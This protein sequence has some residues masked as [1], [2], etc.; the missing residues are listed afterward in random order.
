MMYDNVLCIVF[1]TVFGF[2]VRVIRFDILGIHACIQYM[3]TL[4]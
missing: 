2:G 1:L 3:V 4:N